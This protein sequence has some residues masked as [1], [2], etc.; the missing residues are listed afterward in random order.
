EGYALSRAGG[1]N[2]LGQEQQRRRRNAGCGLNARAGQ[3][4]GL[5]AAAGI[6]SDAQ[7][8]SSCPGCGGPEGYVD[9]A[10]A[11]RRQRAAAIVGLSEV[12]TVRARDGNAADRE[13]RAPRVREGDSLRRAAGTHVLAG[14]RQ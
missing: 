3:A 13:R 1:A 9:R 12:A 5:R 6:V 4:G 10:I 11:P 14:E 7:G 2:Q 8:P